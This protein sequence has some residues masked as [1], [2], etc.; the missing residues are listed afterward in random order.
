MGLDSTSISDVNSFNPFS[1]E[2]S[3]T[4][5]AL[6]FEKVASQIFTTVNTVAE[7]INEAASDEIDADEA[8]ALAITEVAEKVEAEVQLRTANVVAQAE[9][10]AL[11]AEADALQ[12]I[13]DA[14]GDDAVQAQIDLTAKNEEV[15]TKLATKKSEVDLDLTSVTVVEDIAD[16]TILAVDTQIKATKAAEEAVLQAAADALQAEA[17]ALQ[18]IVDAGGDDAAQ[19]QTDL[20]AKNAEVVAKN[21]LT[22]HKTILCLIGIIQIVTGVMFFLGYL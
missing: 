3:G 22:L 17:D 20:T 9:A 1:T 4:A 18:V 5:D 15:T 16:S 19:A 10:D 6:A 11:Q 12:V 14:G 7:A 8:F 13:V 2:N 21:A